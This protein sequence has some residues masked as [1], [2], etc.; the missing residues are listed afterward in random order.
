MA[1]FLRSSEAQVGIGT[2]IIFLGMVVVSA[3]AAGVI[4]RTS[5]MVESKASLTSSDASNEVITGLKVTEVVGYSSNSRNITSIGLT[6][7]LVSGSMD[8]RYDDILLAYYTGDVYLSGILHELS[9]N[10]GVNNYSVTFIR[11][12]TSDYILERGEIAQIWF[13]LED[14]PNVEPLP[15]SKEFSITIIPL[16]GQATGI[17]KYV[18]RAINQMYIVDW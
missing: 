7:E 10:A 4:L 5:S 14:N 18:P 2:L 15:Q 12:K 11:N 13:D 3:V 9:P 6:L 1:N 8:I 17:T 16:G